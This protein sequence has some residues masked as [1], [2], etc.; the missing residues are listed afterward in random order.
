MVPIP[1][2]HRSFITCETGL[3]SGN[4]PAPEGFSLVTS[5]IYIKFIVFFEN[6][7]NDPQ[8]MNPV[9]FRS[10]LE[11]ALNLHH[12]YTGRLIKKENSRYEIGHFDKG[13][14][15]EVCDSADDFQQWKRSNFSYNVV[16]YE[17]LIPIKGYVGRDSALFGTRL[18]FT[19]NGGC[20]LAMS[21]HHKIADGIC[22]TQMLDKF[23]RICRGEGLD[24]DEICIYTDKM[25]KPVKPLPN[26][27]HSILYP[28]YPVGEAPAPTI[29]P[30]P[31]KKLIFEFDKTSL[32][33]LKKSVIESG[34]DSNVKLTQFEVLTAMIH[35]AI[36]KARR[37]QPDQLADLLCIVS[38]RHFH[39]DENMINYFGN[40]IVPVP[41]PFTAKEA[42][43]KGLFQV[44]KEL[45]DSIRS[46]TV[47]YMESLEYYINNSANVEEIT[48]PVSRLGRGAIGISDW[49]RFVNN[50]DV[51][52]GQV[53]CLRSFVDTSPIPLITVMPYKADTV[54]VIIQL[55]NKSLK[56][57]VQDREFMA[58]V[59]SIN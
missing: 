48:S 28:R 14:L 51:G 1:P 22:L 39:P 33:K 35:R 46:M 41:V 36:I 40:Y 54:D 13:A 47:P 57:L 10:K 56:R 5:H 11:E 32:N 58:F 15:F 20:A 18:T 17:D 6:T 55:D 53:L 31:S 30:A 42:L 7:K 45:G 21:V 59:K 49:S 23:V 43:D 50:Y 3:N 52:H 37:D 2:K 29:Q 26:V 34:N 44:A 27:D 12:P 38:Q 9:W 24:E 16:P 8:F 25:R 4:V 19:K